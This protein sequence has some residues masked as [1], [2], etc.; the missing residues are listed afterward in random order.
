[1]H[2]RRTQRALALALAAALSIGGLVACGD[3]DDNGGGGPARP[4]EAAARA[5]RSRCCCRRARR[6]A[7]RRRTG[8]CSRRALREICPDCRLIY[9]NAEQDAARQQQQAEAA[10]TNGAEV[11]VLDPVDGK[12]AA[13][14]VARAKQSDIGVIAYDRPIE[15]ADVDYL[16]TFDN[17]PSARLQANRC[18]RD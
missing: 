14:I 16:I 6:R 13:A 7:T 2:H 11:L 10:I 5:A 1:M 12:A 17:R 15:N 8:R 18:S 3:D 4:A 9:S